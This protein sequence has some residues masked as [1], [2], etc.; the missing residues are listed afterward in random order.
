M[1]TIEKL[2]AHKEY[3]FN[4][5]DTG[6]KLNEVIEAVNTLTDQVEDIVKT[7]RYDKGLVPTQVEPEELPRWE[8]TEEALAR[9]VEPDKN[10]MISINRIDTDRY[11]LELWKDDRTSFKS[12]EEAEAAAI[13]IRNLL[14]GQ[15]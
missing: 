10:Y 12:I 4:E 7:M 8:T 15:S 13:K 3:G 2:D 14:K 6:H 5:Q 1:K 9:E 11:I